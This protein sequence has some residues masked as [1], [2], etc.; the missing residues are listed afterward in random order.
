MDE[1]SKE[2]PLTKNGDEV[3]SGIIP[4]TSEDYYKDDEF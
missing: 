3:N 4:S 2:L 1:I